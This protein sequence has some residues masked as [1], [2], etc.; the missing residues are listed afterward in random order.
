LVL[1]EGVAFGVGAGGVRCEFCAFVC[2][3]AVYRWEAHEIAAGVGGVGVFL[4]K[5]V[6]ERRAIHYD[7]RVSGSLRLG[8]MCELTV[9]RGISP[10]G[11]RCVVV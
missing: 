2:D 4:N 11:E 9:L 8:T 10:A 3:V 7:Y 1:E 6:V 5:I